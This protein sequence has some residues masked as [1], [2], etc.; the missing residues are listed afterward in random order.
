MALM[1]KTNK[2]GF[3]QKTA[4]IAKIRRWTDQSST[5]IDSMMA[6]GDASKCY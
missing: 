3:E 1:L 6:H 2:E 5:F 4:K